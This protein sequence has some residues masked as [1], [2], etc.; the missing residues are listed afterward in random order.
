MSAFF[1]FG[2]KRSHPSVTVLYFHLP[3]AGVTDMYALFK[4][5]DDWSNHEQNSK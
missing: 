2:F 1:L 5:H 4:V 3:Y